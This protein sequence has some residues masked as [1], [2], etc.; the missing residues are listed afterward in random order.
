MHSTETNY[1]LGIDM[2]SS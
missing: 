2:W 1:L